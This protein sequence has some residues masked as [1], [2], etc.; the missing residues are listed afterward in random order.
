M[1]SKG[2]AT[3]SILALV[4][5]LLSVLVV[6]SA[7]LIAMRIDG[8]SRHLC[9]LSVL[10]SQSEIAVRLQRLM[11]LNPG[12]RWLRLK[13]E[14]AET[15]FLTAPTPP[16]KAVALAELQQVI[17][18][19]MVYS[20]RQKSLLIEGRTLSFLAPTR[21]R[22]SVREAFATESS[23]PL[24][25]IGRFGLRFS[26]RALAPRFE[27]IAKPADSPTPDYEPSPDFS[28]RQTLDLQWSV[29]MDALLPEWLS[30]LINAT[31]LNLQASC[32]GTIEKGDT[33]WSAR[34]KTDKP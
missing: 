21:A 11:G 5:L 29:Q 3:V 17:A 34:L 28:E 33:Q 25:R 30:P 20:A 9:R 14:M 16:L 27:V 19:Q 32:S 24:Q 15:K 23:L 4:P 18:E 12:A 1:N 6:I 10:R 22:A 26:S 7:G 8:K 13:R 2:F 31:E